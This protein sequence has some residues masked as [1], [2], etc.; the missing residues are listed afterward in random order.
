MARDP[1][2]VIANFT[3]EEIASTPWIRKLVERQKKILDSRRKKANTKKRIPKALQKKRGPKKK[4]GRKPMNKYEKARARKAKC[5]L[6]GKRYVPVIKHSDR[7]HK[8][9]RNKKRGRPRMYYLSAEKIYKKINYRILLFNQ[10]RQL[11]EIYKSETADNIDTIFDKLVESNNSVKFPKLHNII[12]HT[13]FPSEYSYLLIRKLKGREKNKEIQTA[14]RNEY[15]ELIS[16]SISNSDS[17]IIMRKEPAEIE[18]TFYVYG[19]DSKVDRKDY[20]WIYDNFIIDSIEHK[21]SLIQIVLY[22]NK[23]TFLYDNDVEVV[24]CKNLADGRR[25]YNALEENV[26]SSKIKNVVFLGYAQEFERAR[27]FKIRDRILE[28]TGWTNLYLRLN[29]T[30]PHNH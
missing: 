10:G 16:N 3:E 6:T 23:L 8:R 22:N 25:L 7:L 24:I 14:F 11:K 13:K 12:E 4:C 29:T 2:K 1:K 28:K 17:W 20:Q 18:E 30:N 5:L 27:K 21:Y 26:V 9:H 19:Y 15:G